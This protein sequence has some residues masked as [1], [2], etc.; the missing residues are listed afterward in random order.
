MTTL[1]TRSTASSHE[2]VLIELTP[3]VAHGLL[4]L[5]R[6]V[7]EAVLQGACRVVVDVSRVDCLSS[8]TITAVLWAQRR[9][10]AR[11]GAVVLRNPSAR[12]MD[13]IMRTGLWDVL[14]VE[15]EAGSSGSAAR[16]SS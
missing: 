12:S 9:C 14:E 16:R 11:G 15:V 10:R 13:L 3:D 8:T 7:T 4:D 6:A 5:R 1:T 2:A